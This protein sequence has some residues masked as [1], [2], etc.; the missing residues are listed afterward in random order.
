MSCIMH[1]QAAIKT[2]TLPT[3]PAPVAGIHLQA[4]SLTLAASRVAFAELQSY[5]LPFV[6]F[7]FFLPPPTPSILSLLRLHTCFLLSSRHFS[8]L[9]LRL[10]RSICFCQTDFCVLPGPVF[11]QDTEQAC[12]GRGGGGGGREMDDPKLSADT[13]CML[14]LTRPCALGGT[15]HL[16]RRVDWGKKK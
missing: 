13:C 3:S 14:A 4:S 9:S 7:F 15:R 5:I 6:L 8:S 2:S 11:Q 12:E 16:C 1:W 10:Q